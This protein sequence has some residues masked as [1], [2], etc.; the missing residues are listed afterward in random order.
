[1]IGSYIQ[2]LVINYNRKEAKNIYIQ[3]RIYIYMCV[4]VCVY[5]YMNHFAVVKLPQY[6]KSTILQ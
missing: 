6:C 3:K 1:M 4:C 2:Y 5:I